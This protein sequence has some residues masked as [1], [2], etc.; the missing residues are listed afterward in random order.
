MA[1][2]QGNSNSA[3]GTGGNESNQQWPDGVLLLAAVLV[4]APDRGVGAREAVERV[5]QQLVRRHGVEEVAAH[6]HVVVGGGRRIAAWR[7]RRWRWWSA[8]GTRRRG[9]G[10]C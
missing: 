1:E 7:R 9:R 2:H 5:G 10:R 4:G 8:A 3:E 6:D